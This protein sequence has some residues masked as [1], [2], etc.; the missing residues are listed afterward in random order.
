MK[1][2]EAS[3]L[4]E[5][6]DKLEKGLLNIEGVVVNGEIA[7]RMTHVSNMRFPFVDGESLM[8]N[9]QNDLAMASGS[10]CTAADPDPSHVLM[11]RGLTRDEAK[12]S[13]RFSL[14][15]NTTAE[16]IDT[17]VQL[18]TGAV[19]RLRADSPGWK[20]HQKGLI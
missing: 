15:R 11:A 7:R 2:S 9:L 8:A 14:G 3:R 1:E 16:D 10:A 18:V 20:L 13:I 19:E 6:R 5:L 17:A 4:G 12:W